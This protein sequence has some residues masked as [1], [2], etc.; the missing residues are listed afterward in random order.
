MRLKLALLPLLILALTAKM[1][2]FEATELVGN[3][4]MVVWRAHGYEFGF[5]LARWERDEFAFVFS[6][7]LEGETW[8]GWIWQ[9]A[10]PHLE[11]YG[12]YSCG[13]EMIICY[14]RENSPK[15][16][17]RMWFR[18]HERRFCGGVELPKVCMLKGE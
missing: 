6:G 16:Q 9:V 3:G 5:M 11:N 15:W 7:H 2:N 13:S 12:P 4:Q 8:R 1:E 14:V 10:G 18:G 17:G